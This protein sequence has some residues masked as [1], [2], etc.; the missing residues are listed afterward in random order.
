MKILKIG[1]DQIRDQIKSLYHSKDKAGNYVFKLHDADRSKIAARETETALFRILSGIQVSWA[2]ESIKRIFYEKDLFTDAQRTY[3]IRQGELGQKWYKTLDVVFCIAY[4]L[5]PAGDETC[6]SV[7]IRLQRRQLGS[8]LVNQYLHLR[9]I[10][11][12]HLMPNFAIRN[13][14]QH[15]E[16]LYG[17]KPSFSEVFSQD[18]TDQLQREN[19]VTTTSRFTLVN[20]FYQ[21]IVDM[22]RFKSGAFALDPNIT[23]FEYFYPHYIRKIDFEVKKINTP[24]LDAYIDEMIDREIRGQQHRAARAGQ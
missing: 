14:V 2:E 21:M 18:I 3:L 5:V 12:R 9:E 24:E 23:P 20:A 13:K 8:T 17:F 16:W 6:K 4:G 1:F 11:T 10:I 7:N 22:G 19:I 15:G